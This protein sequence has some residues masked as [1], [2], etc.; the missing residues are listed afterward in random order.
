MSSA[1]SNDD[2]RYDAYRARG[3]VKRALRA[4]AAEPRAFHRALA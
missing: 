1:A 4:G 2:A 3:T